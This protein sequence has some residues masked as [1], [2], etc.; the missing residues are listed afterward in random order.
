M[1]AINLK[2]EYLINPIGI[3]IRHPRL[4]WNCEGGT[5]QIAY[6]IV[7]K[8]DEQIV[9]DSGKVSSDSMHADYPNDLASRQR[10]EWNATLW[11]ETD[12]KGESSETAFFETGLLSASDF[13]AKWI[14]GN[15]RVNPKKRYPVDCF[16]KEFSAHNVAKAR[17]YITACGLYEA[18][19]N[20]KRVDDFVLAPGHTDYTKRIQLQTYDVTE[21]LENGE[22]VITVELADGWYRGSCGAWG[23]RN[24]YGTQTKLY[25][26]L[27]ITDKSGNK[28]VIGTDQTWAWSNDGKIRFADNKDGEIVEAWREP[29]YGGFAQE[30]K[31]D[32][33]PVSSNNVP[34]TEHERFSVQKVITTPGGAKVLDF[35]Q[36]I[37]G[38]ISFAVMAKKG[39]K[40]KLRFG[41]MFDE[42]GEF[43]QK[44]FQCANKKRTRVTPLQQIEY[45]CKDGSNEYKTK[46]AIF[47]F[48]Y[49]LI[50]SDVE[51]KK[52]DFTAVSVCSDMEETLSFDSSN[53]L[54]NKL[55]QATRWSAKNNHADVPTDCPTRER[56]GW[57]GDA[58][59]FCNTASY[60]FNYAP[61]AR[62][63]V[64]DMLDGQRKNGNFRQI[65]PKG[66]VDFY[67]DF[68]DGSAGW[69]D[70]GVLI[71]YRIYK[72]YGDQKI[73][74]NSYAAMKQYADFKIKTLGKWYPTAVRTGIDR[75]YRKYIS[76]YGQSYGE[77][78]EPTE[79]HITGFRDFACPHPEETTAYIVYLL[80]TMA[81]ITEV[82]GK[83]DDKKRFS[84]YAEKAKI[85][86]GK[87]IECPEF[88]LDTDRQ[89]K[90][91]RP[92]YMGLLD[93]KQREFAQKRLITAL[94]HYGWRLGTGFLSTPFIL[95]VLEKIDVEYAYRLLENEQ[96]PGWL[97]MPKMN[98]NTIWE[99]WEGTQAQVGIA[100]LDHYSK[101]AVLEWV[102]SEMCGIQVS[103]EN[104]FTIA[105]KAGGHFTFAKCEYQSVYGKVKSDWRRENGKTVYMISVP[106]NTTAKV[107]LPSGEKTLTAGEYEF[108]VD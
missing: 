77:W 87:L 55:V 43:T 11:D 84:E 17:L 79:V 96:M 4:F 83:Q 49:V 19:V 72:R 45:Y 99:S 67:M 85:G 23:L 80:Q 42:N 32:V 12:S 86:Y 53:E 75:K 100:S 58:Q 33:T 35:G 76:N 48:Q 97:F 31:C 95:Y 90:L 56:H 54:L 5:K 40:I 30:T 14:S 36:N 8:T 88:T 61:F 71:P 65:T 15:Y 59:I 20:G 94:E 3:D 92:L 41:E 22:N 107:V 93:E 51:W 39:Q 47:G 21:L 7:A 102:V 91:V 104:E 16:K 74:E 6:R 108:M 29:S 37:A 105:P 10:V 38:Y 103:G 81:E 69:S 24:Q 63:Y 68:M 82:L 64:H 18:L 57:T 78:A 28:A 89:A 101:G 66:G 106:A 73:L 46:F 27:E 98:A 70:A 13:R 52:E 2:T 62:K 50:E 26:Q 9:W 34:V 25:A 1:K 44:N 60:L